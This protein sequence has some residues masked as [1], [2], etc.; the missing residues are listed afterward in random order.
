MKTDFALSEAPFYTIQGE[1]A[2]MGIPTI[3]IRFFG[4]NF[5]CR[6]FGLPKGEKSD[7]PERIAEMIKAN[8][9][10]FPD[11]KS[12]PLATTGCD[13]FISWHPA[14]R[15]YR[16]W[17]TPESVTA[18]CNGLCEVNREGAIRSPHIVFTGGEPMMHQKHIVNIVNEML[19]YGYTHFTFET[20]GSLPLKVLLPPEGTYYFSVSPKMS[21][22]GESIEEAL[23]PAAVASYAT[24][25]RPEDKLWF[26]F[27]V[28]TEYDVREVK[29]WMDE[30]FVFFTKNHVPF[31]SQSVWLMPEGGQDD[32]RFRTNTK[33]VAQLAMKYGL[34]YSDR[35]QVS[36]FKNSW[37]T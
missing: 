2:T 23:N 34:N 30:Y 11:E 28:S 22:S 4:C 26:K 33:H 12:I 13:S 18:Y 15:K 29:E 17:Y 32:E 19:Q 6:G 36:L 35:L 27:V 9:L 7:E 8:P 20:N 16:K 25:M 37:G 3:F 14:F 10:D 1:G 24:M 31:P 5:Q 21:D